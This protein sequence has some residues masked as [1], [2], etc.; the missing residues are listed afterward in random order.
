MSESPTVYG[1]NPTLRALRQHFED[2]RHGTHGGVAGR[3]DKEER[4]ADTVVLLAPYAK[5]VLEEID[6]DLLRGTGDVNETGLTRTQDGGLAA[7][8]TLSW[9]EQRAAGVRPPT[10]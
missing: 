5:R 2:L 3:A 4:F 10:P 8:W 9:P 7:S 1:D 6:R